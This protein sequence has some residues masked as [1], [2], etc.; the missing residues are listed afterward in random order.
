MK[1]SITSNTELHA[2]LS[3]NVD[4]MRLYKKEAEAFKVESN[5]T[6]EGI[7]ED[8]ADL[9]KHLEEVKNEEMTI[10]KD[11]ASAA[12]EGLDKV[13]GLVSKVS[14][15][16]HDYKTLVGTQVQD[17]VRHVAKDIGETTKDKLKG[18]LEGF[19]KGEILLE[20]EV[21]A[22]EIRVEKSGVILENE[23][24]KVRNV[25]ATTTLISPT[26]TPPPLYLPT[27]TP[28]YRT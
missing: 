26:L 19:E 9:N 3:G 13:S 23:I 11:N 14:S 27:R 21:R 2:A 24:E 4:E 25:V 7:I 22:S 12:S 18:M 17:N 16:V 15:L 10:S 6:M 5:I 28:Y 20:G 8:L 1:T